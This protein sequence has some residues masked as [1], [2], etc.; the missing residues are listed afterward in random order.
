M[1]DTR[2]YVSIPEAAKMCGVGR[3]TMWKWVKSGDMNA[4]VTPGGHHRILSEDIER[5][6]QTHAMPIFDDTRRK[7][8]LIVDDDPAVRS[9]LKKR[10][11]REGWHAETAADG[12]Q[13]GVKLS[14]LRP[15]LVIL[16][17]V[18]PGMDGFEVCSLIKRDRSLNHTKILALTG[19]HT[20]ENK[21]RIM[22]A[23]ADDCLSKSDDN[24]SL[25]SRIL[26]LLD[27]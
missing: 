2:K 18:M 4:M 15:D 13:A 26:E 1:N 8:I 16:D 6:I 23:G 19:H 22:A 5:F 17:L 14:T 24:A 7:T 12:F 9:F 11:T 21:G 20:S 10:L 27:S 3:T 25:M